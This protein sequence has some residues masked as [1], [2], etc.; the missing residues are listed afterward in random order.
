MHNRRRILPLANTQ[1]KSENTVLFYIIEIKS[2]CDMR[3]I[4]PMHSKSDIPESVSSRKD[5]QTSPK[6]RALLPGH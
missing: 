5:A 2:Q 4:A 3:Q 6:W 1:D